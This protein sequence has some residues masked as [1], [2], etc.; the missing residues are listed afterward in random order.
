M[1]RPLLSGA[2]PGMSTAQACQALRPAT[3]TRL[4]SGSN[5]DCAVA[6]DG[7]GYAAMPNAYVYRKQLVD[8]CTCNGRDAFGL[9]RIDVTNEPTLRRG[10]VVATREGL[11]A[12]AGDRNQRADFTPVESYPGFSRSYRETLSDIRVMPPSAVNYTPVTVPLTTGAADS[13][14]MRSAQLAR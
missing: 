4:Y 5:I 12:Y 11:V 1:L 10:D 2:Q 13:A 8:G 14:G 6:R 7:S 3:E 9:A